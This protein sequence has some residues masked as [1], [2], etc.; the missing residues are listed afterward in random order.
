MILC[1]YFHRIA[2]F[3]VLSLEKEVDN[4]VKRYYDGDRRNIV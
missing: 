3:T 4:I 2:A 1:K